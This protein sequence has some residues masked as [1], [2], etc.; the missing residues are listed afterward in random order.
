MG[1]SYLQYSGKPKAHGSNDSRVHPKHGP[2]PE[3]NGNWCSPGG[4]ICLYIYIP[5]GS[6]D[7]T[8]KD[9]GPKSH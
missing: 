8:F 6:K 1:M 3:L 2:R 5:K 7:P 4:S 9:S